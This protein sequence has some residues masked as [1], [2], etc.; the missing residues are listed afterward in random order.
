MK[1]L[2][3]P[4]MFFVLGASYI[5]DNPAAAL[6]SCLFGVAVLIFNHSRFYN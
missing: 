6:S 1:K 5:Q 3:F 4:T 2:I